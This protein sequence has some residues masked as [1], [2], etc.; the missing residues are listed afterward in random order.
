M[1]QITY[2]GWT[3]SLPHQRDAVMALALAVKKLPWRRNVKPPEG[4]EQASKWTE[5]ADGEAWRSY[6]SSQKPTLSPPAESKREDL[7]L[8]VI[9]GGQGGGRWGGAAR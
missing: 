1:T 8:P 7:P 5:D 2:E 3:A 6:K 9:V 4:V